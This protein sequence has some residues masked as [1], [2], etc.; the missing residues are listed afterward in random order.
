MDFNNFKSRLERIYS[1]IDQRIEEDHGESIKVEWGGNGDKDNVVV[2]TTIHIS[3]DKGKKESTDLNKIILIVHNLANLKD[4]LKK[5]ISNPKDI[6]QAIND[7]TYLPIVL[8]LS[9]QEKHGYPLT[10]FRRSF[11][12]PKIVNVTHGMI[13]S[14]G[15]STFSI[16][17]MTGE[18]QTKN[19]PIAMHANIVDSNN[20]HLFTL[21]ELV[22]GAITDWEEIIK[23]FNII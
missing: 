5:I 21:D 4:H 16:D 14:A 7:S 6:E 10:K 19:C 15:L 8:D 3:F 13:V 22:D 20:I 23:K 12:D 9:N 18:S 11:K 2:G 1:S 17:L